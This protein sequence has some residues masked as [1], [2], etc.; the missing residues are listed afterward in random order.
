MIGA[1]IGIRIKK[2]KTPHPPDENYCR[3]VLL[4]DLKEI[5]RQHDIDAQP[6]GRYADDKRADIR[7]SYGSDL[8]V[9]I[10]IKKNSSRDI[11]R[12]ITEQLVPKYVRDPSA[13]GYGIYLVF[14]FGTSHMRIIPP[15]GGIP[16]KPDKLKNLFEEQLDPALRL[17]ISVVV[18][19]V[20]PSGRYAEGE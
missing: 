15:V 5:L 1:S 11:W 13:D 3:N 17:R 4:S 16:N 2:L 18:I 14:W 20:S 10:E 6:E 7:V 19:D 8:A 9:P 12:G